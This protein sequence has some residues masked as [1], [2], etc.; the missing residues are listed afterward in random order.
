[1]IFEQLTRPH[2]DSSS[3]EDVEKFVLG[4][5]RLLNVSPYKLAPEQIFSKANVRGELCVIVPYTRSLQ[6]ANN[7][8]SKF[9]NKSIL[10]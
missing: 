2:I 10:A 3:Y 4:L 7:I 5:R 8:Y 1:M 6:K 9:H